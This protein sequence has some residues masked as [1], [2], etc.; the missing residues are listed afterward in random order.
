MKLRPS[1]LAWA[2]LVLPLWLVLVLCTHWE[3]VMGDGWG[4]A[5]WYRD[6]PFTL[7]ALYENGKAIYLFENPRLGQLATLLMYAPG[8]YHMIVTPILEL[9]V[10]ALLTVL[11]LGR[12]PSVRRTDDAFAALLVSALFMVCVPQIGA[13]LFYRPF[14][15]NYT[16]GLA[17]NLLWLVPY[18]LELAAPRPGRSWRVPAIFVVGVAAGLCNEHTGLA[19]LALGLAASLVALGRGALRGWMIV[20]LVALAAGYIALLTAPGQH[21]RYGG[22]ALQAGIIDRIVKRGVLGNLRVIGHPAA[23]LLPMLPLVIAGIIE[24]RRGSALPI[25]ERW[26]LRALALAGLMC[27]LT[28]LASPKIGPRLFA[29]SV[30]LVIAGGVGWLAVQLQRPRLRAACAIVAAGGLLYVEVRLVAAYSVA[31]PPGAIR[32]ARI[33]QAAPG[34]T[35]T[36]PLYPVAVSRYFLGDDF[37]AKREAVAQ[38]Y[39]LQAL[40]PELAK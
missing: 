27:T 31:G 35:V 16:F 32:L 22:L 38:L 26:V 39:H 33:Q 36:V 1:Y 34:T 4:H 18:R 11:A 20:G 9:G 8:P 2:L 24:R 15:G 3:P 10:L 7:R 25:T 5:A 30:A 29:A 17:L 19:F 13:M 6:H 37:V 14:T 12:W 40:A 23:V 28:L 21:L